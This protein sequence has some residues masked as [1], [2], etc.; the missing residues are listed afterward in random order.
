MADIVGRDGASFPRQERPAPRQF[1]H[2]G[3]DVVCSE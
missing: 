2:G 1:L 3:A